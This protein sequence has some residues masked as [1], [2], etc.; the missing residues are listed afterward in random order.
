MRISLP[1][2]FLRRMRNLLGD[3]FSAYEEAMEQDPVKALYLQSSRLSPERFSGQE[4]L[5]LEPVPFLPNGYYCR[6]E[7]P[8]VHPLHAAGAYYVQD[9]SAM[10]PVSGAPLEPGMRCLDLCASPGGKSAQIR[11]RI[12]E[13]GF[14]VSNEIGPSRCR[15]LAGNLERIGAVNT[16]IT[17][18]DAGRIAAWYP[19]FFD[20][21]LV[22][23]P[24]SGEGMFRKYP[25]SVSEWNEKLPAYCAAR[26]KDLLKAAAGTV[27]PGGYLLYSTCTF[28]TEENEEVVRFLLDLDPSL[29][30][31]EFP[32]A[33]RSVTEPGIGLPACRRFYPFLA[34]GEGQFMALFRKETGTPDSNP[35]LGFRDARGFIGRSDMDAA[36]AFLR[37]AVEDYASLPLCRYGD[38]LI[39]ADYPVPDRNVYAPGV[40]VGRV[41]KGRLVPHHALFKSHGNR[42]IR[43]WELSPDEERIDR[44][45]SGSELDCPLEDGWACITTLGVPVGGVKAV[46]GTAKNHYPKGL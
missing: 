29:R 44:Y 46:G 9:P 18:A 33:V 19:S 24:C 13:S 39:S 22:D 42:F 4:S 15:T 26:Q 5:L 37:S 35:A 1:E 40:T 27:A 17:N 3:R 23:A 6:A 7:K 31:T 14:L 12:G 20:F 43:R 2:P 10:L 11:D 32:D 25:E 38:N 34:P 16:L 30:L 36:A 8:G 45:L 21:V 28:S 41:E